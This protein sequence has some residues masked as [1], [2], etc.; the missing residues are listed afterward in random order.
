M[1]LVSYESVFFQIVMVEDT[2]ATTL[3]EEMAKVFVHY[4]LHI[5]KM[6]GQG[7]SKHYFL[8]IVRMHIMCTILHISYN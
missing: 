3:K 4:D 8:E 7:Y 1:E 2:T 5:E 6:R